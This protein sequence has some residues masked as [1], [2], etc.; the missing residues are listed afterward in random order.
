MFIIYCKI[1]ARC[2]RSGLE[3]DSGDHSGRPHENLII[4]E[5]VIAI[6]SKWIRTHVS[7]TNFRKTL[8][9]HLGM[10]KISGRWIPVLV[11]VNVQTNV[12]A[13]VWKCAKRSKTNFGM[14]WHSEKCKRCWVLWHSIR[15]KIHRMAKTQ[16]NSFGKKQI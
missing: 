16:W 8:H 11:F 13:H 14:K 3:V 9:E 15:R 1:V 2:F 4:E 6:G 5:M 7:E 10:N 12:H